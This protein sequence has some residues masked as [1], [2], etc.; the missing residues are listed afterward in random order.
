[1]SNLAELFHAKIVDVGKN[2]LMLRLTG[3][4]EHVEALL[5][6]LD[7][8]TILE[9]ARTGQ[10]SLSRGETAFKGVPLF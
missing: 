1:M 9:I 8:Y 2:S 5:Q 10:I 7:E 4:E 3:T 6:M